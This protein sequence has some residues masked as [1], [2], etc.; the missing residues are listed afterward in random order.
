MKKANVRI[1]VSGIKN[2]LMHLEARKDTHPNE[3]LFVTWAKVSDD[4]FL[5]SWQLMHQDDGEIKAADSAANPVSHDELGRNIERWCRTPSLI[6][7]SRLLT[8]TITC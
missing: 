1:S 4:K 5:Y 7:R 6:T 8:R 2:S 3:T